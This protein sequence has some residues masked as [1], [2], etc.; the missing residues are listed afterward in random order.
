MKKP[1]KLR[2]LERNYRFR[3]YMIFFSMF[4]L[5][6]HNYSSADESKIKDIKGFPKVN[7]NRDTF[8]TLLKDSIPSIKI[9]IN[10]KEIYHYEIQNIY[11]YDFGKLKANNFHIKVYRNGV[12]SPSIGII[13]DIP[14][15]YLKDSKVLRAVYFPNWNAPDGKYEVRVFYGNTELKTTE[16]LTFTI[17]RREIKEIKNGF[18]VVDLE[19]NKSVYSRTIRGISGDIK[20]PEGILEWAGFLNADALWILSGETTSFP[21]RKYLKNMNY[22]DE[23][24]I[25]NLKTLE[26]YSQKYNVK[27]G[28]Y[29]ISFFVPGKNGVPQRYKS[30][31]GYD[32]AQDYL[33]KSRHI[34]LSSE[35]R[36]RDIINLVRNFQNDPHISYIGFDFIR[37]GRADGYELVDEFIEESN[38]PVNKNWGS[39]KYRDRIKWLAKKIEI[40]NDPIII[41]KWRWWRAHKV[42]L[43]IKRIIKEANLKKTIWVYTLG[44]E[45]GR[46]HGQDPVMFFDAGVDI[47]A[48]MLYEAS[49]SQ[50]GKMMIQWQDYM[51]SKQG[52]IIIGNCVDYKLLDSDKLSPP[53]ELYR[54]NII[55]STELFQDGLTKGIFLH[56]IYRLFW[57]R[58]GN[59]KSW[60]YALSFV[61]SVFNLRQSLGATD[62]LTD[63]IINQERKSTNQISGYLYLKNLCENTIDVNISSFPFGTVDFRNPHSDSINISRHV[64]LDLFDTKKVS[65][66]TSKKDVFFRI[67]IGSENNYFFPVCH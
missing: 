32:S 57:G 28:A 34:S 55:G 64:V 3:Y 61:S 47:D 14:F 30:G 51:S 11:I 58:K 23:G 50:Y 48:V 16:P 33:Y 65:F 41:E 49:N 44:W 54:R 26:K 38:V 42:A 24:P 36:I 10:K 53:Q 59:Y 35:N 12:L 46:E 6:L 4:I 56:D 19:M 13:K 29:V 15:L 27:I 20:G 22:W 66:K 52:N 25:K 43:I 39:M 37:T 18:S 62:I 63:I 2:N 9:V 5:F 21:E 8:N 40:E 67:Q 31:I 45:H 7:K 17:K 60:E 1:F